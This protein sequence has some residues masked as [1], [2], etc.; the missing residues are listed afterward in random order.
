MRKKIINIS[1]RSNEKLLYFFLSFYDY[2]YWLIKLKSLN[3]M[4][5][6]PVKTLNFFK[7]RELK[8]V[9][10]AKYLSYLK[11]EIYFTFHHLSETFFSLIYSFYIKDVN[12]WF[13]LTEY[14]TQQLYDFMEDIDFQRIELTDDL[15]KYLF[16]FGIIGKDSK[17]KDIQKSIKFIRDF[18]IKATKEYKNHQAYNSHKHGKRCIPLK[19]SLT[20]TPT[21][22]KQ[23]IASFSGLD[24]HTFLSTKEIKRDKKNIYLRISQIT[25]SFDYKKAL[26]ISKIMFKLIVNMIESRKQFIDGKKESKVEVFHKQSIKRIFKLNSKSNLISH[27]INYPTS[28]PKN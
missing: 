9:G 14:R 16:F 6:K 19:S 13:V 22:K 11:S 10:K 18:L 5:S 20:I 8:E 21:G 24:S 15:I 3:T 4:I 25:E 26:R 1:E 2:K 17:R 27:S 12:P 23:A 28:N 7:D